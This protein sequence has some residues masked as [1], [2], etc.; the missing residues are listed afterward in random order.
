MIGSACKKQENVQMKTQFTRDR[1]RVRFVVYKCVRVC[2]L[3]CVVC[4]V[5]VSCVCVSC[6][7]CRVFSW[8]NTRK[9]Q[10]RKPQKTEPKSTDEIGFSEQKENAV[11]R[12]VAQVFEGTRALPHCVTTRNGQLSS[13]IKALRTDTTTSSAS[14]RS[15][16]GSQWSRRE[17]SSGGFSAA[18]NW[19]GRTSLPRGFGFP[20]HHRL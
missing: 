19:K 14:R 3:C 16:K 2:V 15:S 20:N 8:N 6:V 17:D 1:W 11:K 13:H 10:G 4:V 12:G 9:S 5:C 7:V 18:R